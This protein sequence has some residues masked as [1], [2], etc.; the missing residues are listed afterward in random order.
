MC[1]RYRLKSRYGKS[2]DTTLEKI[3]DKKY[4][5]TSNSYVRV[6]YE[7]NKDNKPLKECDIEA[8][9]FDGGPMIWKGYKVPD[10]P[11]LGKIKSIKEAEKVFVIEF[12]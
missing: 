8:I 3:E 6:V 5:A 9:D 7:E 12:E 4:I 10:C 1:E 11:H 2:V